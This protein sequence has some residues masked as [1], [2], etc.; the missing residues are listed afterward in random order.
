MRDDAARRGRDRAAPHADRAVPAALGRLRADAGRRLPA[1]RRPDGARAARPPRSRGDRG[2][3]RGPARGVSRPPS[4]GRRI[5]STAISTCSFCRRSREALLA[6][7]KETA[8]R[9]WVRQCGR[10]ARAAAA[11]VRSQGA[12]ARLAEPRLSRPRGGA[13]HRAPIRPSP[14]PMTSAPRCRSPSCFPQF[15]DGLP[16]GGVVMCHPGEVDDELRA[17]RSAHRPAR[18]GIRL[19]GGRRIRRPAAAARRGAGLNPA[20]ERRI[21]PARRFHPSAIAA[22]L[23]T[24][25]YQAPRRWAGADTGGPDR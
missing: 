3:D 12:A 7:M 14:A 1:A 23:S 4:A 10:A 6:A 11:L 24:S 13:R 18:A 8:P 17:A 22:A 16:D 9:A 20:A 5:S 15:L 21:P 2:R 19:F 25:R